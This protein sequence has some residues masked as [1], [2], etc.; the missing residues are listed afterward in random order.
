MMDVILLLVNQN[1]VMVRNIFAINVELHSN[2][3]INQNIF[4][5][6]ILIVVNVEYFMII[7][8]MMKIKYHKMILLVP[9][10][11]Q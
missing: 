11:N 1:N 3:K 8:G 4:Q 10:V 5:R 9:N 6:M 2:I 7:I